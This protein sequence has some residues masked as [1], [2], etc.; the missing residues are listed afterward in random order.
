M[1]NHK[2]KTLMKCGLI[3]ITLVGAIVVISLLLERTTNLTFKDGILILGIVSVIIGGFSSIS[4]DSRG[5]NLQPLG[6][7][8]AQY[9]TNANLEVEKKEI[10]R[11]KKPIKFDNSIILAGIIFGGILSIILFFI[12]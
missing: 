9:V 1:D 10:E 4:G 8:N 5:F 7:V 2:I 11:G 3:G 6:N 12:I